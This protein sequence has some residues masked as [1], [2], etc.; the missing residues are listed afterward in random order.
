MKGIVA[1]VLVAGL[2]LTAAVPADARGSSGGSRGGG[3]G[4]GGFQSGGSH[5]GGWHGGHGSW[6][7]FH[8]HRSARVVIGTGIWLGPY[9]GPY[10]Y[11]PYYPAY[12]PAYSTPVVVEPPTYIEQ[13]QATGYW[14]YCESA[15]AY[16]PYVQQCPGG[17]LTVVPQAAPESAR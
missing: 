6:G 12:P 14:Y 15:K 4:G 3:R 11:P 5:G 7:R 10:W 1:L 9:W 8:G 13:E 2:C 17:W 16:Y